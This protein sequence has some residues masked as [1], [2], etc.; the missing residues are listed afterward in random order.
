MQARRRTRAARSD[1]VIDPALDGQPPECRISGIAQ[2]EHTAATG[3]T[4]PA[5]P[6]HPVLA[7]YRP[8]LRVLGILTYALGSSACCRPP[9]VTSVGVLVGLSLLFFLG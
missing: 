3:L 5:A 9:H 7:Q 1:P 2:I 8:L 6:D 4:P